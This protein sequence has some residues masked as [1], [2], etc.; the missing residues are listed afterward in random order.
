LKTLNDDPKIRAFLR[1]IRL[2]EGT[3]DDNGY[4]R[5]CGGGDWKSLA[6]HPAYA[7]WAG[8]QSPRLKLRSTAAGAYQIN[9]PTWQSLGYDHR[10]PFAPA[11]QDAAA[12]KLLERYQAVD[13]IL[14]GRTQDAVAK[15]ARCWA[16]LP[17]AGYPGQRELTLHVFL[18]E[19]EKRLNEFTA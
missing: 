17:G 18:A 7:G 2:G 16:S 3:A 12:I 1:A 13:D 4:H 19:Y 14:Q 6:C 11:A 9:R 5:L 15:C 10:S 8:W